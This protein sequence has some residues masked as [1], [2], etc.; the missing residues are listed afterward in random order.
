MTLHDRKLVA[1]DRK[2]RVPTTV[3][4]RRRLLHRRRTLKIQWDRL[5]PLHDLGTERLSVDL[6]NFERLCDEAERKAKPMNDTDQFKRLLDSNVSIERAWNELNDPRN[7]PTPQTIIEAIL[8][9]V[10]ERGLAAL[11]EP[12]NLERLSRCDATAKARID[13]R[14]EKLIKREGNCP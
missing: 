12:A 10:R 13:Q 9:C 11:K 8:F 1:R 7:R 5:F 14:I 4:M 6:S 2:A 3:F